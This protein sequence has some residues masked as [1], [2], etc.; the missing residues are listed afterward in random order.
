ML[1]RRRFVCGSVAAG[2]A[3]ALAGR[4]Q[5]RMMGAERIPIPLRKTSFN[6]DW[7]FVRGDV[8]GG[9]PDRV[10][11]TG[12]SR[13]DLPHDWSILGPYGEHEP[14][15]GPGGY[16]PTGIGWYRKSFR[17]P[18]DIRGK[19]VSVLFDGVYQRSEVWIN[20]HLLGGR[21]YGYIGFSFDLTPYLRY[22]KEENLIAVRVDNSLQ[23]NSRWY[24]GSGIYRHV[25]L[26]TTHPLHFHLWGTTI[27]TPQATRDGARITVA[28]RVR[29]ELDHAVHCQLTTQ[30][31]D[32]TGTSVATETTEAQVGAG[33]EYAF[34]QALKAGNPA[35]WSNTTPYL[36]TARQS[37][38]LNSNEIDTQT[39][40]FGIREIRFD[41]D[42]GF[43]LNGE[44]VKLRGMC[45][46]GDGG[47]VGTAVPVAVWRR[48][49]LLLKAMGC[50]A[51]RC[52]HNP[53]APEFLD[54]CDVMGFLVMDE[55]YDEWREGKFQT[56]EYGYHKY[57]DE[58]GARDMTDML[59]R[60]RNHPSIV[61]WSAGN[62][63]PDQLVPRGPETLRALVDIL[64][65]EDPTRPVTA[66]CDHIASEPEATPESFLDLLDV[67]G[68]NYVD[69]WGK[70]RE[71]Y[72]SSDRHDHP[73][74][75]FIGTENVNMISVRGDAQTSTSFN[76]RAYHLSN[77]RQEVE[78]LQKFNATYDYVSGDFAW[79]GIDYLGEARWPNKLSSAG[80]IDTCGFPK[81]SYFFYQSLW[82]QA[83]V[84]HLMPH[85]N[86][87]GNEGEVIQV[88]CFTNCDTVELFLN[89]K[90]LGAKGLNFP[91]SG[92]VG[93]YNKYPARSQQLVTTSN[94]H[95]DWDVVYQSGTLEAVGSR[96]GQV[97]TTVKLGT[98]GAPV[99][100]RLTA[101]YDRITT[102]RDDAA[103]VTIEIVD[104]NGQVVPTANDKVTFA[105][106]G[107]GRILGLDNGQP[108]SHESYQ[109]TERRVFHGIAL[110]ILQGTGTGTML[111]SASSGSL[112]GARISVAVT[113]S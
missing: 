36:Y 100:L 38:Q 63:V 14:T 61:I 96:N 11:Q 10:P 76:G 8:P 13:V 92:M 35:L 18:K 23:P 56:P 21:P 49:L 58:W 80:S 30:I 104:A 93:D 77:Q 1:S 110:A 46:H 98:T 65:H 37:L 102:S 88:S 47:C 17:L 111:L 69:R 40:P 66:A 82:T 15:G 68:Y 22:G 89:G 5:T 20:G 48:R 78:E 45:L 71:R 73:K 24:S 99:A 74:R 51:I 106:E 29:N 59:L 70:R 42:K 97:V 16:L 7:Q 85:W 95:L 28:T 44:H 103:H 50:N 107:P 109:G 53:P 52:A 34:E 86:W 19:R 112:T 57:F 9:Q 12:W 39:T 55:A 87:V 26:L 64:H 105:I 108:D 2:A 75:V 33:A 43:F 72:Y 6:E 84:L 79:T 32:V 54:L 113:A 4:S 94:L 90:S 101:D 67:V 62:E 31:V 41:A 83:P 3:A 91:A 60:D 27:R 25:W 81:D